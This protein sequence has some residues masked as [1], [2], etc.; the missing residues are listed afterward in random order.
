MF[1]WKW[2]LSELKTDKDI[3]VFSCFSCGGGSTMGYK[4]NGFKVVGN[5]EIDKEMNNI[6][7][8]N[9]KPKYNFNMDIRDFNKIPND[10]LPKELFELDILDGSPPCTTFSIAGKREKTWGKE[11]KFREGQT[12]Q[13]LDDLSF[14]FLDTVKKLKPKIVVMENVTGLI[15]GNAKGYVN[16]IIKRFKEL[17]YNV[18]IFKLNSAFMEVPQK[19]ERIFFIANSQNYN[20]LN[21]KFNYDPICFKNVR[22]EKGKQI[23]ENSQAV[24]LLKHRKESDKNL[25]DINLRM[26]NKNVGFTSPIVSDNDVCPTLASGGNIYRNFD[27]MKFSDKDIINVSSF[28]Q[29]Y[30]FMNCSPKYVCGM[31]V[32]PNMMAHISNEI[33]KQWLNKP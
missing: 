1:D 33:Y 8:Q 23:K 21:L 25:A 20:R 30:N 13:T 18:Q 32:P 6:Y 5:V 31:S 3:K 2:Y 19:R 7:I 11:K 14:V 16:T 26:F 27:G 10:K 28:P 24:E 4:R 15:K 9:H 17:N 12:K 22:T 29:D